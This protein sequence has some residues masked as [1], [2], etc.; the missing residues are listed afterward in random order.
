MFNKNKNQGFTLIELL[1]VIA[2]IGILSGIV[3]VAVGD[4]TARARDARRL[5]DVRQLAFVLEREQAFL[6]ATAITCAA[7]P[8]LTTTCTAPGEVGVVFPRIIEP[9]GATAPCPA[10]AGGAVG[11]ACQYSIRNAVAG[12]AAVPW[13]NNYH[14]CFRLER[15]PD[16]AGP[17][18]I[19]LNSIR[20][21]AIIHPACL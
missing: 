6:G 11:D 2:I 13:T 10:G 4:A 16:G 15:D 18:V 7:A 19:G 3:I 5:A 21:G 9:T 20:T 12:P 8:A 17:L 14:I 1:V